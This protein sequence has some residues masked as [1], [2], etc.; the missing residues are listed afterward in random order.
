MIINNSACIRIV[1]KNLFIRT[2]RAYIHLK[3]TVDE[4]L[5]LQKRKKNQILR[6]EGK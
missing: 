6:T 5:R 4:T 3:F 1:Q 2:G